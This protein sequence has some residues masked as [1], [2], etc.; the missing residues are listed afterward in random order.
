MY[1]FTHFTFVIRRRLAPEAQNMSH[2]K[3]DLLSSADQWRTSHRKVHVF[4]SAKNNYYFK[5][6][7]QNFQFKRRLLFL[8]EL[9]MWTF[10]CAWCVKEE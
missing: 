2:L 4:N 6:S 10:R 9:K 5:S 3:G 8:A 1:I 7:N